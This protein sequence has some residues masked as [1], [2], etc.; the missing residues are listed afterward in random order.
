MK[1]K[2]GWGV[3]SYIIGSSILLIALLIATFLIIRL[4]S[5]L[6]GINGNSYED[7]ERK[8]SSASLEYI[9][10]DYKKE[11]STG[12]VVVSSTKL[13]AKDYIK[14]KDLI[15]T[16]NEDKCIGYSLIRKD[17]NDKLTSESFIKCVN[18]ETNGYQSWRIL[19]NE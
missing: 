9:N 1:N 7:I 6:R 12:V 15:E 17:E 14:A 18:Y 11:I 2:N 16:D 5:S 3:A 10:E 13:L 19:N 8:L 4:Y